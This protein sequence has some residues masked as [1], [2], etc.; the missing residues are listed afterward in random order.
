[1]SASTY[2]LAFDGAMTDRGFW[3]YVWKVQSPKGIL[4]YVGMTGDTGFPSANP[5]FKRMG[6]HLDPK[7]LGNTLLQYLEKRGVSPRD[8]RF[9]LLAH[10]PLFRE[11]PYKCEHRKLRSRVASVE[12][13]L[14]DT[15]DKVGYNVMN[16]V[17]S[18]QPLDVDL[19]DQ[20][21]TAFAKHFSKLLQESG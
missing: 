5:P 16:P 14:R 17:N 19:W 3:I 12:K 2:C 9:E 13:M 7:E 20:V 1:M 15:L 21:R 4:L 11:A 18:R 8:C 6:Q 10:G